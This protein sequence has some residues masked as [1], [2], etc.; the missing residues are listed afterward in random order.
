MAL[1][2]FLRTEWTLKTEEAGQ[3]VCWPRAVVA[4]SRI[5]LRVS[6]M[7]PVM[8]ELSGRQGGLGKIAK[9][10]S[11]ASFY[12]ENHLLGALLFMVNI[13]FIMLHMGRAFC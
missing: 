3:A 1:V 10:T 6:C 13:K 8:V 2:L 5:L 4:S 11:T 9:P 7:V 12:M